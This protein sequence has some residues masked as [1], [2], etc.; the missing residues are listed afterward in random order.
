MTNKPSLVSH[1]ILA[2]L[3]WLG[4][5]AVAHGWLTG[6]QA[7]GFIQTFGPT[8]VAAAIAGIGWLSHR[9]VPKAEAAIEK[10]VPA[11]PST[12]LDEAV[13]KGLAALT[14]VMPE[15]PNGGVPTP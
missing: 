9:Y 10:A 5:T 2:A 11:V 1:A 14:G 12:V 8:L 4:A 7:D 3:G 6:K 15:P 13:A